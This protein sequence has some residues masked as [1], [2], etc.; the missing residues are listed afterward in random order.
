M[1]LFFCVA[2]GVSLLGVWAWFLRRAVD[3]DSAGGGSMVRDFG[4]CATGIYPLWMLHYVTTLRNTGRMVAW[5]Q[6][7]L[8]VSHSPQFITQ[9]HV[10]LSDKP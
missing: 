7:K 3:M 1:S 10:A 6:A 4:Y 9:L 5:M 2:S 8:E